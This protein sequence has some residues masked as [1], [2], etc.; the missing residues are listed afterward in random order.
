MTQKTTTQ[1]KTAISTRTAVGVTLAV[2]VATI[3]GTATGVWQWQQSSKGAASVAVDADADG[4]AA[5]VDCNDGDDKIYPDSVYNATSVAW[6]AS[7]QD[8][9]DNASDGDVMY[10]CGD[11][12]ESV[13]IVGRELTLVGYG[14][15][16]H[17]EDDGGRMFS[18]TASSVVSLQGI[19]FVGG[20]YYPSGSVIYGEDSTIEVTGGRFVD[21]AIAETNAAGFV[22]MFNSDLT[23][24]NTRFYNGRSTG[25]S[26]AAEAGSTVV[27]TNG[28][29]GY[30][31]TE[32]HVTPYLA[33]D[34]TSTASLSRVGITANYGSATRAEAIIGSLDSAV[35]TQYNWSGVV[36]LVC[37]GATASCI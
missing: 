24:T 13:E 26:V 11:F 16:T 23:L 4:Y 5:A 8:A 36:T 22:H 3:V 28:S 19:T 32:Y 10:V 25:Y 35:G 31:S 17:V 18:I 9:V 20:S 27:M 14:N 1:T 6:D 33:V 12:T 30:P 34:A 2:V 15:K 21:Y 29:F 37:D 7:I